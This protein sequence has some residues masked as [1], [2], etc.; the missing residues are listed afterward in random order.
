MLGVS[1]FLDIYWRQSRHNLRTFDSHQ[2]SLNLQHFFLDSPE[3]F[4]LVLAPDV[5]GVLSLPD[6]RGRAK[7][8]GS[9]LE[10]LMEGS[11]GELLDAKEQID[12]LADGLLQP[13][14]KRRVHGFKFKK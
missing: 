3:P 9:G 1:Y 11:K 2:L 12:V 8:A 7:T 4:M 6:I 10:V 14:W 13:L 5:F